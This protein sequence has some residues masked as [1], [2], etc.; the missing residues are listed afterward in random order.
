M[1]FHRSSMMVNPIIGLPVSQTTIRGTT[2]YT[3]PSA[4]T[5][6]I[7]AAGGVPL[8]IPLFKD[9]GLL[10]RLYSMIDGLLLCGGGDIAT[11]FYNAPDGGKLTF[12]DTLRDR[13]E[14]S[15]TR[16]A[17]NDQMPTLA[18]CRGIQVLNVAAGGDLVQDIPSEV[19]DALTHST[20][21][22]FAHEIRLQSGSL[23]AQA[24]GIDPASNPNGQVDVNSHH[25]QAVKNVA[26]GFVASA[27]APDG[28]IEGIESRAGGS[29]YFL[30]VQWHPEGMVPGNTIM[31]A[32][33][34]RFVEACQKGEGQ[35][36]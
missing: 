35:Q 21:Q 11:H 30:G 2:R 27:Y 19:P 22:P 34:R 33:F 15:L 20:P 17:L 5:R 28:V 23:L 13:V 9:K 14:L 4:Y 32:L 31:E 6:A 3:L 36:S 25:H 16:W 1:Y 7:V 26:P 10:R 18:I 12:V 8:M 24:L 29:G